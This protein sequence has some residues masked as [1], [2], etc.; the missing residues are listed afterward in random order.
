MAT[1]PDYI[2]TVTTDRPVEPAD[3]AAA[4]EVGIDTLTNPANVDVPGMPTVTMSSE[5]VV[6]AVDGRWA[7]EGHPHAG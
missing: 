4:L 3:L 2:L 5:T 7:G 6:V 1:V